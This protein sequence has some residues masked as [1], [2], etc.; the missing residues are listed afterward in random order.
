MIIDGHS[1]VVYDAIIT[2]VNGAVTGNPPESVG[3][4]STITYDFAVVNP[5]VQLAGAGVT[6]KRRIA[7]GASVLVAQEFDPCEVVLVNGVPF[8][9]VHEG[10]P[11]SEACP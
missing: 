9:H 7:K 10:V 3:D 5:D 4:A 6:P 2:K 8:L 1:I 11:F